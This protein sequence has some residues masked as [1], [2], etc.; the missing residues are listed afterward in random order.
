MKRGLIVWYQACCTPSEGDSIEKKQQ[1][2]VPLRPAGAV[3][4]ATPS[5]PHACPRALAACPGGPNPV[6]LSDV[7]LQRGSKNCAL[8]K[9]DLFRFL[10]WVNGSAR[11]LVRHVLEEGKY[12][13]GA[14]THEG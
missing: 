1:C 9:A 12:S 4:I 13:A 8:E 11:T 14:V 2:G 5:P 10:T 6:P 3:A 7:R